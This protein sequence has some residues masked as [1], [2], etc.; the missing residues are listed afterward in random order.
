MNHKAFYLTIRHY[1]FEGRLT[2]TLVGEECNLKVWSVSRET[3]VG[4]GELRTL[5]QWIAEDLGAADAQVLL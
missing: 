2:V 4:A 5:G 1:P 3:P